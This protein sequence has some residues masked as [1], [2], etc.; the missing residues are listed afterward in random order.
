MLDTL[1]TVAAAW[2]AWFHGVL[3]QSF[4]SMLTIEAGDILHNR[5]CEQRVDQAPGHARAVTRRGELGHP[6]ALA[7]G[8]HP[9]C[10]NLTQPFG[11]DQRH[12][13]IPGPINIPVAVV[14]VH[15]SGHHPSIER[16]EVPWIAVFI[17]LV[18]GA[19][20]QKRPVHAGVK[21]A[22]LLV[23]RAF[24]LDPRQCGVPRFLAAL[25]EFG[26]RPISDFLLQIPRGLFEGNERSRDPRLD[27]TVCTCFKPEDANTISAHLA[28]FEALPWL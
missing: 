20:K 11:K 21:R 6:P 13:W 19:W 26:S 12:E 24:D 25:Q 16:A 3:A 23:G 1:A 18:P 14:G 5:V 7:I 8:I 15:D 10:K 9:S 4:I 17:R 22:P 2:I 27:R 28:H